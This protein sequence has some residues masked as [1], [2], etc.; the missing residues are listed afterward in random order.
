MLYP[1]RQGRSSVILSGRLKS[2]GQFY[3]N[4]FRAILQL[5]SPDISH[6]WA[7]SRGHV[8]LPVSTLK[9]SNGQLMIC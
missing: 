6:E 4:R 1:P 7:T 2:Q 9:R 3:F 8:K 5:Y